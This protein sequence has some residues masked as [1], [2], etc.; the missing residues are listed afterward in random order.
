MKTITV[1][2]AIIRDNQNRIFA[3]Q[4]DAGDRKVIELLKKRL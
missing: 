2:A 4:R 3:T 1:S